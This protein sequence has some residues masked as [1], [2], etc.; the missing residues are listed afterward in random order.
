[1]L[2]QVTTS[3]YIPI[4]VICL[5]FLGCTS[6]EEKANKLIKQDMFKTLYDFE[7][8][9][10]I[11]TKLDSAYTSIYTDSIIK[12]YA[13]IASALLDD[14]QDNIDKMKDDESTMEIWRYSYSSLGRNKFKKAYE[15][16]SE[17]LDET[18]FYMKVVNKYM[19]SIRFKF[20]IFKPQF[21]GWK[22][23]HKF[24]CKTKGGNFDLGDYIYVFDK[25]IKNIISKED[26]NDDNSEKIKDLI[27]EAI[28]S[29]KEDIPVDG[30]TSATP[31]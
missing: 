14:I 27:N 13:S 7:S 31:V 4:F 23:I 2:Y 16:F 11:E 24:R 12:L 1:M 28:S 26:M 29:S 25:K 5:T 6:R 30:K 21:Y 8:Y 18:E 15:D 20:S 19:D 9:E 10:P 17:R 22:A 3:K